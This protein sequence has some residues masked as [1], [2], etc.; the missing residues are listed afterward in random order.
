MQ[1]LKKYKL[2]AFVERMWFYLSSNFENVQLHRKTLV[3]AEVP[4]WNENTK[5]NPKKYVI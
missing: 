3:L 4:K 5:T 1:V 2:L